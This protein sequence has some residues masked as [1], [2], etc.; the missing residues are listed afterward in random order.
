[1]FTTISKSSQF[2]ISYFGLETLAQP[3]LSL[4][5]GRITINGHLSRE[6]PNFPRKNW[7]QM[8]VFVNKLVMFWKR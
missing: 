4:F 7:S 2:E 8:Y 5:K 3:L 1:M 6:N